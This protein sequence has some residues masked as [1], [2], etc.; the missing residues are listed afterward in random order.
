M[1]GWAI[2]LHGG[3]RAIPINLPDERHIPRETA[4][5]HCLDLGV[6]A[7][8]SGK[9]PLDVTEL[10][11]REL[12]NHPDFNAGKGSVLTT[13]GTIEM[14]PPRLQCLNHHILSFILFLSSQL[15][16][17]ALTPKKPEIRGDSQCLQDLSQQRQTL[18]HSH[19]KVFCGLDK[20]LAPREHFPSVNCLISYSKYSTFDPDFINI[21]TKAREVLQRED[22][23]SEIVQ[24]VGKDA[25][26]EGDK[27]TLE[28][29][30]L[31]RED[32]LAQNAFTPKTCKMMLE[33]VAYFTKYFSAVIGK[34][35]EVK[36][37][38][39]LLMSDIVVVLNNEENL[40]SMMLNLLL[41]SC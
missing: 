5:R 39:S 24:L 17:T 2:A 18:L 20:K 32:Y 37:A 31:L 12:E 40:Q 41:K 6:S 34:G 25:L 28:T 23:L 36:F 4:L 13:Q 14:E 8:K 38:A 9:H 7:L 33:S 16:Y 26:A 22:D 30:K 3:A 21:R 10:V 11:V 15:D 19:S 1:V 27:I 35:V 29:A